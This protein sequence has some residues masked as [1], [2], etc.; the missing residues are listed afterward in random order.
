MGTLLLTCAGKSVRFGE[1]GS[2]WRLTH[3]SGEPM[4]VAALRGVQWPEGWDLVVAVNA[5]DYAELGSGGILAAFSVL[6]VPTRVVPVGDT[7][8]RAET[9]LLATVGMRDS[10]ICVRDC[11]NRFD[12]TPVAANAIF[13]GDLYKRGRVDVSALSF[14]T[15]ER[16]RVSAGQERGMVS[17]W[18]AVGAYCFA[19]SDALRA[20]LSDGV[21][22]TSAMV[23]AGDALISEVDL[24]TYRDW[25]TEAAW[26]EYC[27]SYRTLFVDID[28]VLVRSS[29]QSFSPRWGST[30]AIS[31]S[32]RYLRE[33]FDSGRYHI[34]LTTSRTEAHREV[35]EA[36]LRDAGVRWHQLVMGLP[37]AGR[38]LVNDARD[39]RYPTAEALVITRDSDEL[40]AKLGR[41][42]GSL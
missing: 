26:R 42:L 11:D 21:S 24:R 18:F 3:P 4:G 36:Q 28:G 2:K 12:F 32:C 22:M 41:L 33:L 9:V 10:A 1:L 17:R 6:G 7:R 15:A 27:A 40:C 13:V 16:G 20:S 35:T 37:A 14:V 30:P 29:H 5:R 8:S 38:V 39:L 19:S 34:V 25:G 31:S 23:A